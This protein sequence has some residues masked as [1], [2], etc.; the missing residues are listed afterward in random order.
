MKIL[1]VNNV[2]AE[3]S[4][5]K[6]TQELH[7]SLLRAGHESLVIYGRGTHTVAPGVIRLCPDWYGKAN[8]LLSRM[9]GIAHGGCLWSTWRLQRIILREQPDVVHLQ[10][11]NGHFVNIARLVAWLKKKKI[12]TVISLHA[13]F[14]YTA[15]CGHAF[16][17]D[18]WKHGCKKCPDKRKAVKSYLLDRTAVAWKRMKRAFDGF[19]GDCVISPVSPWTEE[20]ARESGILKN[21]RFYT[22]Y[23]GVNTEETFRWT[24]ECTEKKNKAVLHVTAHF[25]QRENH[26]KGGWYL[27]QLA[28]RMPD[29]TFYVAGSKEPDLELPDNVIL[30]GEITDQKDLAEWYRK[31]ALTIM[32]SKK[33]TFSMPCA[34]SLCCGTPVI[35]F[36]SGAPEQISLPQYSMFVD[37]GNLDGLENLVRSWLDR[38]DLDPREIAEAGKES[39]SV[40][41]MVENFIEIYRSML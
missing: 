34:E 14:I 4:T 39:Y 11:I 13:E 18:Q 25:S 32:V 37:H 15:N 19:E 6:I 5:G 33:E 7:E 16:E 28:R 26:P 29:V 22:V 12:K 23:N 2:Y 21:F 24:P 8:S 41:T 17:C 1:Q 31:A 38:K 35:G 3:K 9:T 40:A 20:R 10:C 36:R 27:I 30:L